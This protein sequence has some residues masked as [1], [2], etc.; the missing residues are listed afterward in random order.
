MVGLLLGTREGGRNLG[1]LYPLHLHCTYQHQVPYI[2]LWKTVELISARRK[3]SG[4]LVKL[5][6]KITKSYSLHK[7]LLLRR[8]TVRANLFDGFYRGR[9]DLEEESIFLNVLCYL[10]LLIN[11]ILIYYVGVGSI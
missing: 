6:L 2:H 8:Y 1:V 11:I 5:E 3:I 9:Y 7:I 4:L 10:K